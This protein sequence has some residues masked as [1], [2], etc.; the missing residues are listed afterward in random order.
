MSF[1][2]Q[3]TLIGL[4]ILIGIGLT[5]AVLSFP[6]WDDEMTSPPPFTTTTGHTPA[7]TTNSGGYVTGLNLSFGLETDRVLK[8][9]KTR[10][11]N[12]LTVKLWGRQGSSDKV[13]YT[14]RFGASELKGALQRAC[15][16]L[17]KNKSK[18][19]TVSLP[20]FRPSSD[21][22]RTAFSKITLTFNWSMSAKARDGTSWSVK[23]GD[24]ISY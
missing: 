9:L 21:I 5:L 14:H 13:V 23:Y 10:S 12:T 6:W 1:S 15:D 8:S 16:K 3:T 11:G 24:T 20:V 17:V 22:K 4:G 18:K 7:I 19:E 2:K